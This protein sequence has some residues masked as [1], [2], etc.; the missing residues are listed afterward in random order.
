ML[1]I[2]QATIEGITE[3][4]IL[5]YFTYLNSGDFKATAD[6]FATQGI[7]QPPFESPIV[8]REAI[9]EYL[10]LEG[11]GLEL[12]PKQGTS[13]IT[14]DELTKIIITGKVKTSLFSI[15]V[16]WDYILTSDQEIA[17]AEIKLLEALQELLHL[18][19]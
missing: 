8:G 15:N 11:K 18:K 14:E 2:P 7:L 9:T 1:S 6:L 10:N 19:K 4:V 3:P 16:S 5:N 12:L 17:F 13:E